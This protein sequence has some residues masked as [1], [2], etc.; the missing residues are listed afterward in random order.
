MSQNHPEEQSATPRSLPLLRWRSAPFPVDWQGVLPGAG[1]LHLEVGFGDG[2]YTAR[3]AL[4]D[5]EGRFVG[6]ELSG[7]SVLRALKRMHRD[8]VGNVALL[9]GEAHFLLQQLFRA[10]SLSSITVN[11]PDP[12]PKGRHEEN[13][14]LRRDFFLLA[15]SRLRQ[16]GSVLLATDHPGY[17]AFAREQALESGL[18]TLGSAEPPAAVFETKYALKWKTMGIPLHYQP[19]VRNSVPAGNFDHLE[20]PEEMP[21]SLL[22]GPLPQDSQ[23]EKRVSRYA[24]GHVILHEAALSAGGQPRWLVRATVDEPS[25]RQQLLLVVQPREGNELIVR[26]ESFGDPIVTDAVRGAVHAVTEWAL[27]QPGVSIKDRRY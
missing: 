26:L 12:W 21:H 2:R 19:F 10:E 3:R 6:I 14:L 9:K 17:L 18:F 15:A 24:D 8:G 22:E 1:P 13:R 5:P 11:F 25:L 16:D 20:R 7:V 23:F 27:E 4:D